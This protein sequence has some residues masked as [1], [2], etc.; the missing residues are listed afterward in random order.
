M[1]APTQAEF[2]SQARA[3]A[4][5]YIGF[6]SA[7]DALNGIAVRLREA[8]TPDASN[9][10]TLGRVPATGDNP[11]TVEIV[12]DFVRRNLLTR[13][14]GRFAPVAPVLIPPHMP[15]GDDRRHPL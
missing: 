6:V 12:R 8:H 15:A 3:V 1:P 5:A 10:P 7:A 13:G 4:L 9:L 14:S 11:Q 2:D